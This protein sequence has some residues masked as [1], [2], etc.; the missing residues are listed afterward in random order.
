MFTLH[1][2][3]QVEQKICNYVDWELII[4]NPILSNFEEMVRQD[5]HR[6]GLYPTYSLQMVL[7]NIGSV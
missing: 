7:I 2:M 5:L 3:N 1:E 6:P 4:D